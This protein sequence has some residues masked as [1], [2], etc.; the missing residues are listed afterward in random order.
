MA[1]ARLGYVTTPNEVT[2]QR[3]GPATSAAVLSFKQARNIVNRS[4]QTQADRIVGKMT[5]RGAQN[6]TENR[7]LKILAMSRSGDSKKPAERFHRL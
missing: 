6:W 7:A 3:Y 5:G 2:S 4:Y 1:L